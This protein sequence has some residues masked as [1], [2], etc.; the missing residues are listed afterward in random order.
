MKL[1]FIATCVRSNLLGIFQY[2]CNVFNYFYRLYT[3]RIFRDYLPWEF[4]AAVC[5]GFWPQLFVVAICRE[6]WSSLSAVGSF[7]VCEKS[8]FIS[9][10][11]LF[12]LWK[13]FFIKA[14]NR[15]A[16]YWTNHLGPS[17]I[18][19]KTTVW[20]MSDIWHGVCVKKFL[21]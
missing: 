1:R 21:F 2:F 19:F 17:V 15:T 6:N 16:V 10:Q 12:Y 7:C 4:D 14:V 3:A 9:E 13:I 8:L 20:M 11:K 18:Y 5:R